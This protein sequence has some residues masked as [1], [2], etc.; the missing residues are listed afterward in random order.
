M[1]ECVIFYTSYL[2]WVNFVPKTSPLNKRWSNVL[3]EHFFA[4]FSENTAVCEKIIE[5]ENI[6]HLIFDKKGYSFLPLDDPF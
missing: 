4:V 2:S 1:C 5:H 6:Y 3:P